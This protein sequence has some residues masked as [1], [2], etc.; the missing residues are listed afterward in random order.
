MSE[1]VKE[2]KALE[3]DLL[4]AQFFLILET[5]ILLL[6]SAPGTRPRWRGELLA[7]VRATGLSPRSS[8]PSLPTGADSLRTRG[9]SSSR[10]ASR[11]NSGEKAELPGSPPVAE[12]SFYF[13]WGLEMLRVQGIFHGDPTAFLALLTSFGVEMMS[14]TPLVMLEY[15]SRV[16]QHGSTRKAFAMPDCYPGVAS[17]VGIAGS[18]GIPG[19]QFVCVAESTKWRY[20]ALQ[21]DPLPK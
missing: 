9:L 10:Y 16:A 3:A 11:K 20:K 5:G 19:R 15:R 13:C 17:S 1:C 2:E 4:T 21:L 12:E 18:D 14:S 8:R 7:R 6:R